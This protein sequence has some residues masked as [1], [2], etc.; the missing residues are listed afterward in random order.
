METMAKLFGV[1]PFEVRSSVRRDSL[2]GSVYSGGGFHV[3]LAAR[4]EECKKVVREAYGDTLLDAWRRE[5]WLRRRHIS[6]RRL[7]NVDWI[8]P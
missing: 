3:L 7:I 5:L 4:L 1:G 2:E 6:G 8:Q